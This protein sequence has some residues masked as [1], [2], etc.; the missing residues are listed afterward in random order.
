MEIPSVGGGD[1]VASAEVKHRPLNV[2]DIA[3]KF[4]E[5]AAVRNWEQF[6]T[7][8]N[9]A[10]ALSG[11]AGQLLEIFRWLTPEESEAIT[12]DPEK[13]RAVREELADILQYVIRLAD[14]LDVDLN[15]A[16]GQKLAVNAARYP[17]DRTS[18]G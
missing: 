13:Y 11:E 1:R 10:M 14:L 7:P 3:E 8:K 6:H 18:S 16:L 12:T 17:L 2:D 5:F 4:R 15:T 9:L